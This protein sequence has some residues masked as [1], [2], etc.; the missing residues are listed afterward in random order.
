MNFST[1]GHEIFRRWYVDGRIFYQK[2]I[3]RENP[4]NGIVRIK[5]YRPRKIKKVR[6]VRKKEQHC[7]ISIQNDYE[8]Y[9]YVSMKKV[10]QV[11]L[12]VKVLRIA[13]DT[14][15]YCS[16]GLIDQNKNISI[17]LFT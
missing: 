15:A 4:K 5:I 16:S 6:E 12:Q 1:K 3:D 17:I 13:V 8:E 9:I 10:F 2:L 14:I 7:M 11:Q